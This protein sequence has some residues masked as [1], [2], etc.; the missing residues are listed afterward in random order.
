MIDPQ[1]FHFQFSMM[2]PMKENCE[3]V[4]RPLNA[5]NLFFIEQQPIFKTKNP[6]A[7]GNDISKELGKRWKYMTEEERRPY[8]DEAKRIRDDFL[9]QHPD[10]HYEKGKGKL[11]KNKRKYHSQ[12][13][14]EQ[15][16]QTMMS[17]IPDSTMN[18]NMFS[19]VYEDLIVYLTQIVFKHPECLDQINNALK[20]TSNIL[21]PKLFDNNSNDT[22]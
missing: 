10:Y 2:Q 6:S 13:N 1:D 17:F 14:A 4:K 5:Y 11:Q 22:S 19:E 8:T 21:L 18:F 16:I 20:S 12:R 15:D 3:K 7:S 9:Q